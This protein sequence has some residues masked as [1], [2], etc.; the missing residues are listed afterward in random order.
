ME[1]WFPFVFLYLK[2]GSDSHNYLQYTSLSK[3]KQTVKSLK[4]D[5][6]TKLNDA[7]K[8]QFAKSADVLSDIVRETEAGAGTIAWKGSDF[9]GRVND[10]HNFEGEDTEVDSAD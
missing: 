6:V 2:D 1:S 7:I 9:Y 4:E 5:K 10:A 8:K 3:T